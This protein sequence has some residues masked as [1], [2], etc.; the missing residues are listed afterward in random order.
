MT[1]IRINA[2]LRPDMDSLPHRKQEYVVFPPVGFRGIRL[3]YW[4]SVL[5]LSPKQKTGRSGL[6][7]YTGMPCCVSNIP[8]ALGSGFVLQSS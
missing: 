4:K 2:R 3:H 7:G 6:V 1:S 8:P 5:V